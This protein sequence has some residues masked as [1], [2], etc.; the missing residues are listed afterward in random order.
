MNSTE[1]VAW[2]GA[3]IA[4]TVLTWDVVKWLRS[5]ARLRMKVK[6]NS[7]YHDSEVVPLKNAPD[8]AC[9]RVKESIH[10]ELANVG[11]LPTTIMNISA[12]R[13]IPGGWVGND[14]SAFTVHWGKE[15]P[16]MISPGDIWS[17]RGDQEKLFKLPGTAPLEIIVMVSHLKKPMIEKIV[18]TPVKTG[19]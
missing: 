8:G 5:G 16:Y 18:T 12:R 10:I 3:V 19:E 6:P 2:W 13:A 7:H 1:I 9:G 15:L 4:T 14:S 11:A 17:C